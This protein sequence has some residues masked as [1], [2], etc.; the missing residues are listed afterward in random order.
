MRYTDFLK[1]GIIGL[2]CLLLFIPFII[3]QGGAASIFPNMFFPFIT[4]KNFAFRMIVEVMLGLY[5]LLALKDPKY[6]PRG[7]YLLWSV[8]IFVAWVGIATIF[9]VDPV[10][11]FWSNFERMEGY[12]G[13]IHQIIF[14]VVVGAVFTA[15]QWWE[16][17]FRLSIFVS[18]LEGFYGLFQ[19]LGWAAIS[20]QS[21]SRLDTSFGNATYLAVYMLFNIFLT[22]YM[23]VRDRRSRLAQAV[24]GI[25]LVLQV[26]VLLNTETRGAILGLL[27]GL[28]VAMVYIAWKAT[29]PQFKTLRKWSIGGLVAL[30]VLVGGFM[31]IRNTSI[32]QKSS[33]LS[34]LASIS[35][36]DKTTQARFMI[37]GMAY[38][39]FLERPALGWGQ[40]NFSYVFN[41]YYNP[42]MYDQEQWF[43]RAHNEFLDWLMAAG[44]P[45]FV[46]FILFFL[47]SAWAIYRSELEVPAQAVLIGLLAGYGFHSM[48]VF[49]NLISAMYFFA[50]LA[51]FASLIPRKVPRFMFMARP[52]S[53]HG[54]AIA[55]PVALIAVVA[56]I[57]MLNVP[58]ITRAQVIIDA[59]TNQKAQNVSGTMTAVARPPEENI[60]AFKKALELG[61]LGKQEVVEQLYQFASNLAANSGVSP[62]VRQQAFD[63][64]HSEG[65]KA[66]ESRPHDARLELFMATFLNQFSKHEEALQYFDRALQ[67]SPNKQQILFQR[68][69]TRLAIN[70]NEGGL[71]DLK[72]AFDEAPAYDEARIYY[73][74][75]LYNLD[76]SKE[77][78]KLLIDRYGTTA[79]DNDRL[80]QFYMSTKMYDRAIGVWKTRVEKNPKD[81]QTRVSLAAVYFAKGDKAQTIAELKKAAELDPSVAGQIQQIITQIQ[82]GTLKPQ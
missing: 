29:E 81:T 22:L 34:R 48:F 47:L 43:D 39:G 78:D 56:G 27:G 73:A 66:L 26:T 64:A 35:L 13:L 82:N 77:A 19:L 12:I 24:Y 52:L 72:V 6:R 70:D 32:V 11:S 17:F 76:R 58:G 37:W 54:V 79:V 40:E 25:A 50:M 36:A 49:D 21:G 67:D 53:D 2:S 8:L 33:T 46:L 65:E 30:L 63:L 62:D 80:L 55:A 1:W 41:K 16:K 28:L 45:A 10:K 71:A 44:L 14:F 18:V 60:V 69:L 9:S 3:A 5:V 51:F 31:A 15:E 4:G 23:L 59:I 57:W 7:S 74:I 68:A 61:A 20:T 75:G 42:A 38:Q